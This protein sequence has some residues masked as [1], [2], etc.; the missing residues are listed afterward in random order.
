MSWAAHWDAEVSKDSPSRVS[1]ELASVGPATTRLALR[2]DG[3][4]GK[5]P[6]YTSSIGAWPMLMSSLKSLVETGR[7]LQMPAGESG[8]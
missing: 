3:F 8:S 4:A 6:T 1:Y 5:T 2:H 7:P